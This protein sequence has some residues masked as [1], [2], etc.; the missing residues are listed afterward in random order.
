MPFLTT[1]PAANAPHSAITD[2]TDRSMP[3]VRMVNV[4]PMAT[5]PMMEVCRATF[6]RFGTVMK[7]SVLTAKKR[8]ITSRMITTL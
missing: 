5:I 8:Q 2:P 4:I 6:S 1:M 7:F 3:A